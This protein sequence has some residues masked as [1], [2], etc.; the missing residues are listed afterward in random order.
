MPDNVKYNKLNIESKRLQ[1]IIRVICFRTKILFAN[2]L[3]DYYNKGINEK[4]T[5]V[6]SIISS[7][8]DIIPDYNNSYLLSGLFTSNPG[9][10]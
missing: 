8:L 9:N 5:L 3:S 10:E 1:N 6:K 4:R 2:L 7:Y